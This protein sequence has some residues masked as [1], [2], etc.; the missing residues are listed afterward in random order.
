MA[1]RIVLVAS[2]ATVPFSASSGAECQSGEWVDD[3]RRPI[4]LGL[5]H[6]RSRALDSLAEGAVAT[7]EVKAASEESVEDGT[8]AR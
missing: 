4:D 7:S 3:G 8:A 1:A 2:N 6:S 5:R